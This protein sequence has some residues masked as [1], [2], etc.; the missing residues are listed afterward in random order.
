MK[1][2]HNWWI[3]YTDGTRRTFYAKDAVEARHYFM[4]EGDHAY[5]FG[6]IVE[7]TGRDD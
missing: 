5:D 1:T 4:M 2:S 3:I 6:K 7:R